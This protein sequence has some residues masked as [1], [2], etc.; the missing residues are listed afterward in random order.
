MHMLIGHNNNHTNI[1]GS[2]HNHCSYKVTRMAGNN[3]NSNNSNHIDHDSMQ[4][5]QMHTVMTVMDGT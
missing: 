3:N 4:A 2:C 5:L 1:N